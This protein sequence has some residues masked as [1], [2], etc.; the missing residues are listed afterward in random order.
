MDEVRT[1]GSRFVGNDKRW[2]GIQVAL[3]AIT[4]FGAPIELLVSGRNLPI[5][6][7]PA[8]AGGVVLI[9]LATSVFSSAARNLGTNLTASPT[10]VPD[11]SLVDTGIYGKVRHPMYL[12]VLLGASGWALIFG[13]VVGAAVALTFL[14]FLMLKSRHE[15]RKLMDTYSG[16]A[17][18][19]RRVRRRFIPWVF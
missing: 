3:Q 1:A 19:K 8:I 12:A 14:P 2:V 18:Y 13:S 17:E 15:E 11:G 10:P 7:I 6:T 9:G 5:P 4:L 16:Y